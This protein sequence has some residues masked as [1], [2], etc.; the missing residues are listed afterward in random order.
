MAGK[1]SLFG[2][3][4]THRTGVKQ[5]PHP[6]DVSEEEIEVF[7]ALNKDERLIRERMERLRV[8]HQELADMT[9]EE[10]LIVMT[11]VKHHS[12]IQK[13]LRNATN[14]VKAVSL[15]LAA[16][17]S[18]V[19]KV[20]NIA[21]ECRADISTELARWFEADLQLETGESKPGQ[22]K[23]VVSEVKRTK[24]STMLRKFGAPEGIAADVEKIYVKGG[25]FE[26]ED[27]CTLSISVITRWLTGDEEKPDS[28]K[29][30]FSADADE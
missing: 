14:V 28:S 7:R 19:F 17:D 10:A 25:N 18:H 13:N 2:T 23:V 8:T 15:G 11:K 1:M 22:K 20:L 16:K 26:F 21:R 12:R 30:D 4:V 29:F 27:V 24:V 6:V 9:P 5:T 3:N